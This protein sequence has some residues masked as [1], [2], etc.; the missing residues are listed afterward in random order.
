MNQIKNVLGELP[1]HISDIN[2]LIKLKQIQRKCE[3]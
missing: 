1:H 2:N 3:G